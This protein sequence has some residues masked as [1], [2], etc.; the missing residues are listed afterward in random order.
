[1]HFFALGDEIKKAELE[2]EVLAPKP[3]VF[4]VG[5]QGL[6]IDLS[7]LEGVFS[8]LE[9]VGGTDDPEVFVVRIEAKGVRDHLEELL[10]GL[11][12]VAKAEVLLP[13]VNVVAKPI[14]NPIPKEDYSL[15]DYAISMGYWQSLWMRSFGA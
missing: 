15:Q 14:H 8:N 7:G 6:V 9:F 10:F 12:F 3:K 5:L 11:N 4:G 13:E 2:I 1:M